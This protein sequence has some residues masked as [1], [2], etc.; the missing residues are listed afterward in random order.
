MR[1]PAETRV[2]AAGPEYSREDR[3]REEF[4]MKFLNFLKLGAMLVMLMLSLAACEREGPMERTG[5]K[6]DQAV[7]ETRESMEEARESTKEAVK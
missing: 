5:E 4:S 7:E 1:A 3:K 6:A 2:E